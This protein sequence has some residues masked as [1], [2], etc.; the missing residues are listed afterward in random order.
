MSINVQLARVP[1]YPMLN[2][3]GIQKAL[4][5]GLIKLSTEI[6]D[7][8][9]QPGSLDAR[10]GEV[11]VFDDESRIA[12]SNEMMKITSPI[13]LDNY[14]AS[15][16]NAKFYPDEK[17]RRI[18]VP[19]NAFVEMYFHEKPSFNIK[20]FMLSY[21]FRSSRGRLGL[22]PMSIYPKSENGYYIEA[23]NANSNEIIL[24]G[25]DKFANL[26]FNLQRRMRL[27][28]G[29]ALINP[30]IIK[31][32]LP[33]FAKQNLITSQGYVM[34]RVG[35]EAKTFKRG[36]IIDTVKSID[37]TF[38]D[39]HD[40]S[41]GYILNKD[42][43]AI[44]QLTPNVSL[45]PDLGIMLLHRIPFHTN[46]Q[47]YGFA[48]A[49]F[50]QVNAGWVDQGYNGAITAHPVYYLRPRLL[51]EGDV[52]CFGM[53]YKYNTDSDRAYGSK[54]LGSHYQGSKGATTAKS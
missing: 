9:L 22:K 10:I 23:T 17:G 11:Y 19:P 40:L 29:K 38:Y 47:Q 18:I 37:D 43:P 52:F 24:Y 48:I 6:S 3:R 20:D 42:T 46:M 32:L 21:E 15:R 54:S 49:D 30:N 4:D 1:T 13:E 5:K 45:P 34:F 16:D 8:Q 27:D 14:E 33:E 39:T 12:I 36:K 7:D 51:K 53:V 26:F 41:K 25:Q 50:N 2:D 35:K 28:H 31:K 44:V